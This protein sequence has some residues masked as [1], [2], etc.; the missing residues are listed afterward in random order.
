VNVFLL[1]IVHI[2]VL[3]S[4]LDDMGGSAAL[5]VPRAKSSHIDAD[6]YFLPFELACRSKCPRIVNTSLDCLQVTVYCCICYTHSFTTQVFCHYWYFC[7]ALI[8]YQYFHSL[9]IVWTNTV[10]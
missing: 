3:N 4:R 5:P 6:K 8:I 2:Y 7:R 10:Y 9:Q 1:S